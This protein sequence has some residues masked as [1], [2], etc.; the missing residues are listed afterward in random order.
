[1][2]YAPPVTALRSL[3]QDLFGLAIVLLIVATLLRGLDLLPQVLGEPA[4][5][6]PFAGLAEVER[7]LGE[8]L[9]R[10]AYFPDRYAWPPAR[11][12]VAGR[13]PAA[14]LLAFTGRDGADERLLLAQTI[15]GAGE[16]PDRL[17]P[18]AVRIDSS[19]VRLGDTTA[20]LE[21]LRA[22]DGTSWLQVRWEAWGRQLLLR[23]VGSREELLLMVESFRREGP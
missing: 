19:P 1:M 13:R 17:L 7:R 14:V 3:A 6:R 9:A 22:D 21:E 4:G 23:S 16:I 5:G 18:G 11:I 10:P 8:R 20:R 15:G 12:R 2:V